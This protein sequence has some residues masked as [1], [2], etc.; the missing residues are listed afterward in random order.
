MRETKNYMFTLSSN[1]TIESEIVILTITVK[2]SD[3]LLY[4][5]PHKNNMPTSGCLDYCKVAFKIDN[6]KVEIANFKTY[7]TD[8]SVVYILQNESEKIIERIINGRQ[9][10]IELPY[11]DHLKQTKFITEGFGFKK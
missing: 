10:I 1:D 6:G 5:V 9:L 4:F 2:N 8:R 7:V 3:F 11:K